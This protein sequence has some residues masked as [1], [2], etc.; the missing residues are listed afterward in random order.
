MTKTKNYTNT[1]NHNSQV[2][3]AGYV[4]FDYVNKLSPEEKVWLSKFAGEYYGNNNILSEEA[5]HSTIDLKNKCY[6]T[7]N[8]IRRDIANY[9]YQATLKDSDINE[10][11]MSVFEES[12]VYS[13]E[14]FVELMD[15]RMGL[16]ENTKRKYIK[17]VK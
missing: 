13:D 6:K 16:K 7:D 3:K 12:E 10:D 15:A 11:C 9:G 5:I 1:K 14:A 4:D 17:K 8:A 2:K